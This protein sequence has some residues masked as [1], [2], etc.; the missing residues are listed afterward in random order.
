[1]RGLDPRIH[2]DLPVAS[3]DLDTAEKPLQRRS[4]DKPAWIAG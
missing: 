2:A 3:K 1:M 4:C